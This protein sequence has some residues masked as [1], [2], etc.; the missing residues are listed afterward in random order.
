[1]SFWN[2]QDDNTAGSR[3][4]QTAYEYSHV[5]EP[6]TGSAASAALPLAPATSVAQHGNLRSVSCPVATFCMAVDKSGSNALTWNGTSWSAPVRV[7]LGRTGVEIIH[8]SC[9][10]AGFCVAVDTR[11]RALI[12]DRRDRLGTPTGRAARSAGTARSGRTPCSTT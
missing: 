5:L 4:K 8:V 9:A 7:E 11:G 10:D 1:M 2:L 3:V 12:P 6:F